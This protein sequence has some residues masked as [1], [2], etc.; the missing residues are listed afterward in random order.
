MVYKE[1]K[2][3]VCP[4]PARP[5]GPDGD[6]DDVEV[7]GVIAGA[8]ALGVLHVVGPKLVS[9]TYVPRSAWLSAGGGVA[10]AYVFV[11]LLPEVARAAAVISRTG[12]GGLLREEGIWV[13][14]LG[15]F[16]CFFWLETLTRRT[17]AGGDASTSSGMFWVSIGSYATYNAVI[18]YL[19]RER[20]ER[21]LAAL[22]VFVVAMGVHF[23]V[24]DFALREHHRHRYRSFGRWV[25]VTAIGVGAVVSAVAHVSGA[26]LGAIVAFVAGG[27]VLNVIKEELPTEAESRF[28]AFALA[29]A[30]YAAVLL[31]L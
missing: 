10:V 20:A 14:A 25:L 6:T 31:A 23:L 12:D 13:V 11:H 18:G 15:G 3:A 9:I 24:N 22:G 26:A 28:G 27:V 4:S 17:R 19:L 7:G 1:A 5:R 16:V 8:V 2:E 30:G 29:A 21:G